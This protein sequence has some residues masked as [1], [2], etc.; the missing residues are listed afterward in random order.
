MGLF[1]WYQNITNREQINFQV[2]RSFEKETM[3]GINQF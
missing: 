3:E 2:D 1:Y